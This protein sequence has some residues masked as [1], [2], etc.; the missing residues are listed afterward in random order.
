MRECAGDQDALTLASGEPSE[1]A[2]FQAF[3][4]ACGKCLSH[5]PVVG[6]TRSSPRAQECIA[7]AQHEVVDMH[8]GQRVEALGH[9]RDLARAILV[10][11]APKGCAVE[12]YGAG[13]RCL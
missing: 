2:P 1:Q 12:R 8:F 11:K 13:C 10:A 3:A 7:A 4:I 5:S 6:C 9:D